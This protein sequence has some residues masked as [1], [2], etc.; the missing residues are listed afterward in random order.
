MTRP[1]LMAFGPL[2]IPTEAREELRGMAVN[3]T[4]KAFV[5]EVWELRKEAAAPVKKSHRK[6]WPFRRVEVPAIETN[7]TQIKSKTRARP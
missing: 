1:W 4:V 2:M 5:A 7:V 6:K 3:R